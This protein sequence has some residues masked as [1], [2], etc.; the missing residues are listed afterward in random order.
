MPK[1]E[2]ENTGKNR[3]CDKRLN[4]AG[5][6][7]TAEA[8]KREILFLSVD[9]REKTLNPCWRKPLPLFI[10]AFG[11]RAY[12]R[13]KQYKRHAEPRCCLENRMIAAPTVFETA[14]VEKT[15]NEDTVIDFGLSERGIEGCRATLGTD[16]EYDRLARESRQCEPAACR[17]D[18]AGKR[19][20]FI[21]EWNTNDRLDPV[22]IGHRCEPAFDV[23]FD[24]FKPGPSSVGLVVCPLHV[25]AFVFCTRL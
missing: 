21:I 12:I 25:Y 17:F 10:G 5:K 9:G 23:L 8:G 20:V 7:V 4:H 13:W 11:L 24:L 22:E 6:R 19:I 16:T 1:T 15:V 3:A 14:C 2:P 18:N